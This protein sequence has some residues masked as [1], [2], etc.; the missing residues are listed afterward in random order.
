MALS[1]R[2]VGLLTADIVGAST[3]SEAD[4]ATTLAKGGAGN[5]G[6]TH[7]LRTHRNPV[8]SPA[9]RVPRCLHGG[10]RRQVIPFR[11][12]LRQLELGGIRRGRSWASFWGTSRKYPCPLWVKSGLSSQYRFMSALPP[13]ADIS[14]PVR[15]GGFMSTRHSSSGADTSSPLGPPLALRRCDP[16]LALSGS[17]AA[18]ESPLKATAPF[19]RLDPH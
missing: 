19:A 4:S 16:R 9:Q 8:A 18:G 14:A 12:G 15:Q 5:G 1:E 10:G 11:D 17:G 6:D 3:Q 7:Y 13:K 2:R